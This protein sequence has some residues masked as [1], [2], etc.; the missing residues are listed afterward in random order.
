MTR[1]Q[2]DEVVDGVRRRGA[3]RED[4][5]FDAVEIHAAHGF[6]LSQ[7]LSPLTNRRADE[8]GGDH[9]R[10]SRIHLDVLAAVRRA[11]GDGVPGVRPA[12]HARRTRPAG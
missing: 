2:I 8:Y 4:G 3:A 5:G 1:T 11:A 9:E 6:L 7:F 12:G 10:R